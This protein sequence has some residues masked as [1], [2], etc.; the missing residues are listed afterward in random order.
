MPR[1]SMLA[2]VVFAGFLALFASLGCVPAAHAAVAPTLTAARDG[3]Q[4][5]LSWTPA[6]PGSRYT[7]ETT[8]T[9]PPAAWLPLGGAAS[10]P[11]ESTEWTGPAPAT[12]AAFYR[13]AVT[14]TIQ[15]GIVET[16]I[17][18]RRFTAAE[19]LK[20]M[21][22]RGVPIFTAQPADA[23]K[24]I[25]KTIDAH[26]RATRASALLVVPQGATRAVPLV[27][28]QHGT[29]TLREDVPSRLN[30][31]AALG[32]IMGASGYITVLPDY[33]GLGDS[34]GIHPY[35]HAAS[36]ATAVVDAIRAARDSLADKGATWNKQLFLTGYSQGGHATLAAQRELEQRH[37]EEL[38]VT[39]SA[40]SAGAYDLSGT[41]MSDFLS[42]RAQP[43]PYYFAYFLAAYVDAYGIAA[44]LADMLKAPYDATVPP[45]LDGLHDGGDINAALPS[46]PVEILKPEILAAFTSDPD[47]PLRA[48]L[49]DNDLHT[50]WF[51]RAKTRFY[52]CAGDLDV[53]PA[54]S[55]VAFDAFKA[56]G[57]PAVELIDPFA[58]S[59]HSGC[60]PFALLGTKYWFD[61]LRE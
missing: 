53:L 12:G 1:S 31:E 6:E 52:H 28:Y 27:S 15:R 26:G 5:R 42:A 35:H 50:G 59:D 14:T 25:Y 48:A 60:V 45:L 29:V 24:I 32:L 16:N 51:P 55:T 3:D 43:N 9:L 36:T 22:D 20:Q 30:D 54:N 44:S 18:L 41:T 37:A 46:R 34:P 2:D 40:P 58:F 57:A 17:L 10:W 4:L 13:L 21:Q 38:P 39:A 11:T 49:R 8:P 56:A 61:G 47:H 7:I 33:L 19:L 23:W